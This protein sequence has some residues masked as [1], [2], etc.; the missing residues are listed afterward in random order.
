MATAATATVAARRPRRSNLPDFTG[1]LADCCS[2]MAAA[3]W[4][5]LMVI[6]ARTRAGIRRA[7]E[8]TIRGTPPA[9]ADG[10]EQCRGVG[11]ALD[12]GLHLCERGALVL[13][14]GGQNL[15]LRV[16]ARTVFG[17]RELLIRAR[18]FERPVVGCITIRIV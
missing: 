13:L 2:V 5:R 6:V 14:L 7:E 15:E 16:L 4:S 12:I 17:S 18:G 11:E 9:A 8:R 10:A 1:S 3:P